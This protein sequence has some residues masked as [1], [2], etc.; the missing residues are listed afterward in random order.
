MRGL[1]VRFAAF[2]GLAELVPF[3]G[4]YAVLFVDT[5]LTGGRIALLF[6]IWSLT[7][8]VLE[9]PSG[10]LADVVS[11]RLVLAVAATLKG[12]GFALWTFAP[13]FPAFAAGFVLW[14]AASAM[15][16]GTLQ[17]LVYDE[18]AAI[19]AEHGYQRLTATA[20]VSGL[21]CAAVGTA[22]GAPLYL[23]GGYLAVG[24]ASVGTALVAGGVALSFPPRPRVAP[25]DGPSGI[26]AW[27]AMLRSGVAEAARVPPVRRLVILAALLPSM[28]ALDEF[29]PLVALDAGASA[30]LIPLLVLLPALGQ[31][32]GGGTAGRQRNPVA[33]GIAVTVGGL[34]IVGG[35]LS[36]AL[37]PGFVAI[38]I[39]YG[40]MQHAMIV[41]DA[42]LQAAVRGPARATVTSV[43]GFGGEVLA[44]LLF[45]AWG[46]ATAPLGQSGAVAAVA[47]PLALIGILIIR[48]SPRA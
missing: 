27:A 43:A 36:G 35:A 46:A 38:S 41:I 22:A 3:Y 6:V 15:Q 39:G 21:V 37:W 32:V 8:I 9:V 10:A 34:L 20:S 19:G 33:V 23:L 18:L 47:A 40:A 44:V 24:L 7:A 17:A 16:S 31:V 29:F 5:G 28:T 13:G 48:W 4:L 26:L 12:C 1:G 11:R 14:G 42:R 2:T 45:V 25:A 30:A